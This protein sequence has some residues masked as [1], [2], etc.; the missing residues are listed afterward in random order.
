MPR[1]RQRSVGA[2]SSGT[3]EDVTGFSEVHTHPPLQLLEDVEPDVSMVTV[4]ADADVSFIDALEGAD[5]ES[6]S[7]PLS[8]R[9]TSVDGYPAGMQLTH[10]NSD[11]E[12]EAQN[13]VETV[14]GDLGYEHEPPD[15]EGSGSDAGAEGEK[16]GSAMRQASGYVRRD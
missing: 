7:Q 2:H 12:E 10:D 16:E 13:A 4:D 1:E 14:L 8:G 6:D 11:R 15:E 3:D 5:D 9:L